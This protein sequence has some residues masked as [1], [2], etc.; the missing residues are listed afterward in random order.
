VKKKGSKKKKKHPLTH[1]YP[2]P[3]IKG[4]AEK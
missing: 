3:F 1:L 4:K 2:Y